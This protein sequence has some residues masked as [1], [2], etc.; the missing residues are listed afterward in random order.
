VTVLVRA[1]SEH[2]RIVASLRGDADVWPAGTDWDE[3]LAVAERHG[4]AVLLANAVPNDVLRAASRRSTERAFQLARQLRVLVDALTAS[5]IEVLPIKGPVLAATAYGDPAR[6]GASGDLDL[7]VR[8]RDFERAVA[9]LLA[10]GYTRHEGASDVEHEHEQWE[11]EAHLLP[12][13]LP[14]TMVELHTELIGNFHTAPVNLDAVFSR[15]RTRTLFGAPMRV[16]A[17][18]DLLLYL[19]L[20]GARH[21]W[22]RLLWV[23]DVD[24]VIRGEP[25]LDWEMLLS[26]A[27]AIDATRRLTLGIR[28]AQQ[29]LRTPFPPLLATHSRRQRRTLALVAHRMADTSAGRRIPPLRLRLASEL[30]ARET[31]SQ[32]LTYLRK[33]FTPTPRDRAWL[34]LPRR[35]EWLHVVLRPLRLLTRYGDE[36]EKRK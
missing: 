4:V 1:P 34:H 19:C 14:A 13:A 12:P 26:R 3:V 7:V 6:R 30:A 17:P 10:L 27:A 15:A 21:L 36:Y 29:L 32:R 35:L 28:L 11:S 22:S 2:D 31:L 20:H 24:A 18:E 23:C 9:C 25:S 5:G 16:P 33:Q 8:R